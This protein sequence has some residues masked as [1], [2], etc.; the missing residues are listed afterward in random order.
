MTDQQKPKPSRSK[1]AAIAV[2]D[3][4]EH[5]ASRTGRAEVREVLFVEGKPR[6]GGWRWRVRLRFPLRS[7]DDHG[8]AGRLVE[9]F[10]DADRVRLVEQGL[11]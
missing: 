11:F 7:A 8:P 3:V 4:V 1:A 9:Q 2:G 10:V 5:R 6:H